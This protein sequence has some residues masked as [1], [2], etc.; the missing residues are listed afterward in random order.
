MTTQP[1]SRQRIVRLA[2]LADVTAWIDAHVHPVAP[3]ESDI[4][5]AAGRVLANDIPASQPMPS[6]AISLRDGYALQSVWTSD[7]SSYAP[8]FLPA[9]PLRVE[10]GDALPDGTDCVATLDHVAIKGERAEALAVVAPGEGILPA[11]GDAAKNQP[12]LHAGKRLRAHDGVILRGADIA[13]VNIRAPR[14]CIARTGRGGDTILAAAM[15]MLE[16]RVGAAGGTAVGVEGIESALQNKDADAIV[17]IGG[18]GAGSKDASV[19][20]L[21]RIGKLAFHGI[22]LNPGETAALGTANGKP[23]LLVPGRI[24]AALACWLL[25]GQRVFAR[26]A[27]AATIDGTSQLT[28]SRKVTST[29]GIADIILLRRHGADAEPIAGGYWPMQTLAQADFYLVVPPESEGF[30]AGALVNASPLS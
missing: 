10:T 14:I 3:R 19:T 20:A 16:A 18:T 17:T 26:L 7:A 29:I 2:P 15:A 27:G 23:V 6:Q 25:L 9:M 11:G 12:L 28:L 5:D 4:A 22:G 1:L 8:A 24:D 30:P 21:S 13:K